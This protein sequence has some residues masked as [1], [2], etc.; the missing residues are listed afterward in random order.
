ML[1]KLPH[2]QPT[3]PSQENGGKEPLLRENAENQTH[4]MLRING[5]IIK[6]TDS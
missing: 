3:T 4:Q 5:A 6:H 2:L 1:C